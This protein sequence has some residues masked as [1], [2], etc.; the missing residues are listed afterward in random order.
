MKELVGIER[1]DYTNKSG[2][3]VRGVRIH[4]LSPLP[5][6]HLGSRCDSYYVSGGDV[7]CFHLGP[8]QAVLFEPGFGDRMNCVGVL[9]VAPAPEE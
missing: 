9:P 2:K 6:P 7:S 8:I 3:Q 1:V 4:V 5:F